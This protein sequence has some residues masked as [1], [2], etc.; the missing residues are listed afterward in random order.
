MHVFTYQLPV[1]LK[2]GSQNETVSITFSA[3]PGFQTVLL[4]DHS[5]Q[6]CQSRG[7]VPL[8]SLFFH[9]LCI[10]TYPRVAPTQICWGWQWVQG[11]IFSLLL[12]EPAVR[13]IGFKSA[14]LSRKL[15][16]C[17]WLISDYHTCYVDGGLLL[18]GCRA[19]FLPV[20]TAVEG[21]PWYYNMQLTLL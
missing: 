10:Y 3:K 21:L 15:C 6:V 12:S 1:L 7:P 4:W 11:T 13:N 17:P 20:Y 19:R 9:W 2:S 8:A 5:S 16:L 14:C 18:S